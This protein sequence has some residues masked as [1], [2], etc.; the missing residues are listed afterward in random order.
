MQ[1][2]E[3]GTIRVRKGEYTV[4]GECHKLHMVALA[5]SLHTSLMVT[6]WSTTLREGEP[7]RRRVG[8]ELVQFQY[9][10]DKCTITITMADMR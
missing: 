3:V 5:D 10:M 6:N 2:K 1:G 9:N 7:K 8:G 4:N